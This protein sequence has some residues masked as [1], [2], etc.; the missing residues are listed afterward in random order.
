VGGFESVASDEDV[1]IIRRFEAAGRVLVWA[2]D[3]PVVTSA[4]VV[5]RAPAGFA[6]Y[7]SQLAVTPADRTS[8]TSI[9]DSVDDA[10]S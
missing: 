10:V 7:L 4:R 2:A 6:D 8:P 5:G 1:R 9:Q 3:L